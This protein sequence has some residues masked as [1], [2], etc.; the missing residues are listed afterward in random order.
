MAKSTTHFNNKAINLHIIQYTLFRLKFESSYSVNKAN[1]F[2]LRPVT[3]TAQLTSFK[4]M[5]M[6]SRCTI[7]HCVVF[8]NI[9]TPTKA[10]CLVCIPPPPWN[11]I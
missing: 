3:V 9:H 8:E 2:E 4:Q 7:I 5:Y 11:F 1:I 6:Y 10:G